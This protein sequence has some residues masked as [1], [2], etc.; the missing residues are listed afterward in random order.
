MTNETTTVAL[1][2]NTYIA[3]PVRRLRNPRFRQAVDLL[4]SYD[5]TLTNLE[6]AIPDPGIPPAYVAGS[7]WGAT[8]MTGTPDMLEDLRFMGIDGV[9]AANNHVSDFGDEGVL[10]TIRHLRAAGMPYTG[11]GA[12]LTEA[13]KAGYVE[14]PSG[15]RVAF[16]VACDWGP[17]SGQGLNFPWPVGYF[18]SDDRPPFTPRPGVNLLRYETVTHVRRDQL[19][20]LRTMSHELGWEHDKIMRRSGFGRSHPLVGLITN[21]GVEVDDADTVWFLGRKFIA[22]EQ[23]GHHTEACRDDLARLYRQIRE[24]RRQADIV[25]VGLHDQ[26]HGEEVHGYIDEFAHGAIDAGADVYFNNGGSHMGVELYKGKPIIYGLPS[27]FLQTEAVLDVPSSEMARFG[28]PDD[29]TAAD[30][31]DARAASAQRS[32]ADGAPLGKL[33]KGSKGTAVHVCV[34]DHHGE[35]SEVR[36]QPLEPMGGTMFATGDEATV[37]RFRRMLPLLPEPDSPVADS[38]LRFSTEVSNALGTEVDVRDGTA[39]I[40]CRD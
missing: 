7:G 24:A 16:I 6:C 5:V 34:F 38:V 11:I 32:F 29:A 39:V 35:I 25:C 20:Q 28:L 4:R 13:T 40:R 9:C 1:T 37:P 31:L 12:S 23:P 27:L 22:A 19:E 21:L 33:M 14:S 3:Q 8:Y 36:V 18:P 26:S 30:F 2:G 17:R 10:A 15:L